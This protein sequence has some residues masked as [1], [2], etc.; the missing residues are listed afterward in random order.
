MERRD[1]ALSDGVSTVPPWLRR[2]TGPAV[3]LRANCA[4]L[5]RGRSRD[6]PLRPLRLLRIGSRGR[7]NRDGLGSGR[8][9]RRSRL[10]CDGLGSD[11]GRRRLDG[12]RLGSDG[13]HRNLGRRRLDARPAPPRPRPAPPRLRPAPPQ[14][15]PAPPPP[16]RAPPRPRRAPPRP[17]PAPPPP[18]RAPPRP[19]PAP[20]SRP[21][22]PRARPSAA[23]PPRSPSLSGAAPPARRSPRAVDVVEPEPLEVTVAWRVAVELSLMPV[24]LAPATVACPP[25]IAPPDEVGG[26]ILRLPVHAGLEVQVRPGAA[27]GATH[28]PDHLTL[29]HLCA[30]RYAEAREMC[31][32]GG[33]LAGVRDADDVSVAALLPGQAD[34]PARRGPDRSAR[35]SR[36]VDAVVVASP[37]RSEGRCDSALHRCRDRRRAARATGRAPGWSAESR[38]PGWWV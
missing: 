13:L 26:R 8:S 2:P 18:R 14:P 4:L 16:R 24:V 5:R 36:D 37:A 9:G 29:L 3:H 11:L 21:R 32:T 23:C 33:E 19:R 28:V 1:P 7:L 31:V 27:A 6:I 22:S 20:R 38:P 10:G 30:A 25:G 12:N 15:R 34:R 17:R 35:G